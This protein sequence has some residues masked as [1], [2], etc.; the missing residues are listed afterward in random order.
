MHRDLKP[1]NVMV[2]A[3][4][5]V[6]V[7]DW[8]IAK[9]LGGDAGTAAPEDGEGPSGIGSGELEIEDGRTTPGTVLGTP[10]YM[11]PEQARGEGSE[12]DERSDVYS[13]GRILG[14]ALWGSPP[15]TSGDDRSAPVP[16]PPKRLLAIARRATEEAP[17][18]RY[19]SAAEL[20]AEVSRFV[21]G[22]AVVA[23][24]E[25]P[26]DK[27]QRFYRRHRVA[28]L[29]IAAYVLMRALLF[30]YSGF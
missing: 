6:L 10:G 2:G 9:I 1:A 28:V 12:V 14:F 20:A 15:W 25:N 22:E 29:L 7:M 4:G 26:F 11:A 3:F 16:A 17:E 5:E 8:G 27:I 13:L 30:A 23:Y 24:R 18:K 21:A 19:A